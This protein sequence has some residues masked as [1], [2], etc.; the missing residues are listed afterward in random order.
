MTSIKTI[1]FKNNL[2]A[3]IAA[4]IGSV[5]IYYFASFHGIGI[6]PDSLTYASVARNIQHGKFWYQFDKMPLIVFPCFY[7]SFLGA[8]MFVFQHD[9]FAITPYLNA[10][11]FGSVIFLSG[12]MAQQ[13]APN[14]RFYKWLL[15]SC[16]VLSSS[17]IEIF[18]ML[19][20][21][22][23]FI[24]LLLLL[25]IA[26]HNYGSK[27]TLKQLLIVSFITAIACITRFAGVAF[28]AIV[29]LVMLM[30]NGLKWQKKWWHMLVFGLTSLALLVSNLIYNY[31]IEGTLTGD[32]QKS[33]TPFTTNFKFYSN[34]MWDWLQLPEGQYMHANFIGAGLLLA[35]AILIIK[36]CWQQ[37]NIYIYPNIAAIAFVLYVV[38]IIATASISRYEQINN[39]LLSTAFL[40][41]L[42]GG[43]Y[44]LPNAISKLAI[45]PLRY[46][47]ALIC[48]T[49][50]F[51]FQYQQ[52]LWVN[53][54][55]GM[56]ITYG[57]PGYT[58]V[59]WQQSPIV[60]YLQQH[61]SNFKPG[62]PIYAN[63]N[64]AVY[65]FSGLCCETVPEAVHY[66]EIKNY[67]KEQPHYI[68]WFNNEFDNPN[69]LRLQTVQQHR[70][71]DTLQTFSDGYILMCTIK[72]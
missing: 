38:F 35:F 43:T 48:V 16:I 27:H 42:L 12:C 32:R 57:I 33:L 25:I 17:L 54:W 64:D 55:R 34:V 45:K 59:T 40:P 62:I 49:V 47:A 72:K 5:I 65:Y 28:I 14:A 39:R 6:S 21:E 44:W 23:L 2:D 20:S 7:P 58:D 66:Q 8:M 37:Q 36:H 68:V 41:L 18:S 63:A 71:L 4:F 15:L 10:I 70:H 13:F 60:Q 56:V 67:Y 11:L 29:G 52:W 61:H 24:P 46:T 51:F 9:I 26:L 31:H 69:I 53:D 19:W 1:T 30:D 3:I 50:A 22:T